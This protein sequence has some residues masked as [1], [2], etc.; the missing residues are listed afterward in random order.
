MISLVV[1][2]D[3]A[4]VAPPVRVVVSF[5]VQKSVAC[6][7]KVFLT[8]EASLIGVAQKG[9]VVLT[10]VVLVSEVILTGMA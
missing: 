10:G 6:L 8:G 9:E 5:V 3:L 2:M 4:D 1:K 7:V